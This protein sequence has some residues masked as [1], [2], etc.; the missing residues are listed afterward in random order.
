[1]TYKIF[2]AMKAF[3]V[4]EGK[5]LLLKESNKYKDGTNVWRYDIVWGRVE[6]WERFDEWL[7]REIQEETWLEVTTWKPFHVWEW[8][9]EVR[10]EKW[11][12]IA[13]FFICNSKIDNII[14]WDDHSEYIWINPSQ[15][16]NY[17]IIPNLEQA[18]E[19]YL[20]SK[21]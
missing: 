18:F 14:L 21:D 16:K 7:V 6:P 5:I 9:P 17:N 13:T 10:W 1:M 12:I 4:F 2:A 15:Y 20:D 3:V 11:Q 8:R 19:A